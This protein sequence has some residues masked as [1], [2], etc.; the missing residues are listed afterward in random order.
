MATTMERM[1]S[2]VE[3]RYALM[4]EGKEEMEKFETRRKLHH[5][6]SDY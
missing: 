6:V 5:Y 1:K 2:E 3:V 4:I